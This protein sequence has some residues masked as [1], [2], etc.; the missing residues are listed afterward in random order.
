M[1]L[2]LPHLAQ[3]ER[4]HPVPKA[5]QRLLVVS[6]EDLALPLQRA[7][8][9]IIASSVGVTQSREDRRGFGI[10]GLDDSVKG[11]RLYV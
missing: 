4:L 9:L 6:F 11:R 1:F 8:A 2:P 7:V 10:L 3:V 5:I